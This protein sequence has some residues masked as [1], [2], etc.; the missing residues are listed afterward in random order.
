MLHST[1]YLSHHKNRQQ[2]LERQ[3]RRERLKTEALR[4]SQETQNKN[5]RLAKFLSLFL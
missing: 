4:T 1:N 3:A 2:E 5:T